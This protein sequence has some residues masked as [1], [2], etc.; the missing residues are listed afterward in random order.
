VRLLVSPCS[1]K[2]TL[3]ACELAAAIADVAQGL[4]HETLLAPFADG[5]DDTLACLHSA[6]GGEFVYLDVTGPTGRPVNARYLR[7]NKTAV[8]ELASASGIAHLA[9]GELDALNAQTTGFGQVIARAIGDGAKNI[10]L[11]VGGSASTDGGAGALVALG[12]RLLDD[13]GVD[14]AAG[15]IGLSSLSTIDLSCL[16]QTTAGCSFVVVSDVNSPL[17][18]PNG[19]AYIFAPQKGADAAQ[20]KLLDQALAHYASTFKQ[21]IACD[22]SQLPGAGSAGGTGY[23][24]AMA[25]DAPVVSGFDWL[26]QMLN[27][28]QKLEQCDAIVVAEGRIDSQSFDSGKAVGRLVSRAQALHKKVYALPAITSD[29]NFDNGYITRLIQSSH[30]ASSG[31]AD[32]AAV[33]LATKALLS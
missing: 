22:K 25:L 17:L 18:G 3:S 11:T 29:E 32:I 5:G 10:Y 4:G 1:Y 2:G 19:A 24:L 33:K 12:A 15:G 26:S 27:L 31:Q 16:R 14:I 13:H 28:E 30:Y 6:L 9:I 8:V 20:V 7:L 21:T 23:G